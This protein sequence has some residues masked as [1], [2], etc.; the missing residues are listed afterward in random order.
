MWPELSLLFGLHP[1]HVE[2]LTVAEINTYVA[3]VAEHRRRPAQTAPAAT[4]TA[5]G[6]VTTYRT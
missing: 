3:R 6:G 4:D 2:R 5:P 1:W